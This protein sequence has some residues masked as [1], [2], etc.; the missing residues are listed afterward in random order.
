MSL[1]FAVRAE[2]EPTACFSIQAIADAGLMPRV[3]QLFA[4]RGLVPTSWHSRV[5]GPELTIDVQMRELPPAVGDHIAAALRQ[6]VG[7]EVVLVSEKR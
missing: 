5:S 1:Q 3:L 6:I 2:T 7:V 4:K